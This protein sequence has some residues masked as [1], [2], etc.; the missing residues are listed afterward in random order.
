[1]FYVDRKVKGCL[2]LKFEVG[3]WF[4]LKC[5]FIVIIELLCAILVWDLEENLVKII[6]GIK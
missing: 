1:M 2:N 6:C 3:S 5:Y 4:N